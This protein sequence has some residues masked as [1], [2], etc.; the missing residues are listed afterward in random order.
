MLRRKANAR[1]RPEVDGYRTAA[2][3][4]K[5]ANF[6]WEAGPLRPKIAP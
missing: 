3:G 6:G 5:Q 1:P 4:K 2:D